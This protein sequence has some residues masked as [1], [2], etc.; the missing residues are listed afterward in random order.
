[1]GKLTP[2]RPED[3][4]DDDERERPSEVATEGDDAP[5]SEPNDNE[6]PEP[7]PEPEPGRPAWE[8]DFLHPGDKARQDAEDDL[9]PAYDRDEPPIGPTK[10]SGIT[11]RDEDL[12]DWAEQPWPLG[13]GDRVRFDPIARRWYAWRRFYW[14]RDEAHAFAEIWMPGPGW[15]R[16]DL[17]G[18]LSLHL[19]RR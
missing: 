8:H 12:A 9:P 16:I 19:V 4:L 6:T 2:L 14:S 11:K 17:G 3:L 5:E 10:L 15:L 1:M 7:E 13:I 18:G